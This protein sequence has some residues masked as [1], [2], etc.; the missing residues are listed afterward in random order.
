MIARGRSAS[1]VVAIA[2]AGFVDLPQDT[3]L[4]TADLMVPP[5]GK[6]FGMRR[7]VNRAAR[8]DT[9]IIPLSNTL[10]MVVQDGAGS[11]FTNELR[12]GRY[13][14]AVGRATRKIEPVTMW[15]D[16]IL[17]RSSAS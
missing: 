10:F 17:H 4:R 7:Y 11:A 3:S 13:R 9:T 16:P 15:P 8:F 12:W 5:S 1:A 14:R 2:V 6:N